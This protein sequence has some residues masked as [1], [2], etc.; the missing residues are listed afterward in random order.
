MKDGSLLFQIAV[1]R[2]QLDDTL[3]SPL[4]ETEAWLK[5]VEGL[6]EEGLPTSQN[7]SEALTLIRGKMSLFK[8][9][10]EIYGDVNPLAGSVLEEDRILERRRANTVVA[11]GGVACMPWGPEM[12]F[13]SAL[14]G[15]RGKPSTREVKAGDLEFRI[16]L[17]HI[18][19]L[20][21]A[22]NTRT[23]DK[24]TLDRTE[25]LSCS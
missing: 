23:Y 11:E 2:A 25:V 14:G 5:D 1:W 9:R 19:N 13:M 15:A 10:K 24:T 21:P 3:P 17:G 16:L 8:V 22:V 12:I 4:K 18:V 7:S 20:R 6:K